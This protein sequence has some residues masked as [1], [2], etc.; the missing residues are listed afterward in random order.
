MSIA[1]FV[2]SVKASMATI[3]TKVKEAPE[4]M[5][6]EAEEVDGAAI[7][8]APK[9]VG[10]GEGGILRGNLCWHRGGGSG[11]MWRWMD[12][13]RCRRKQ[14]TEVGKVKRGGTVGC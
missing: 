8:E 13:Y 1:G 12:F 3:V 7:L 9:M 10:N 6:Q 14:D 11:S 5:M 2:S 4:S